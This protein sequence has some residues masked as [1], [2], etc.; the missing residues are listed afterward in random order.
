MKDILRVAAVPSV[1]GA[2][3]VLGAVVVL[4]LAA[5]LEEHVWPP[6]RDW[7]VTE[8]YVDGR[9]VVLVGL[10]VKPRDCTYVPPPRARDETG[11]NYLVSST[12]PTR[13]TSW[14]T[15]ERPQRF[16][17]WRVAGGA[18]KQLTFY[19]EFRCHPAWNIVIEHG[20]L[21]TRTKE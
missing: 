8:W 11:Q 15:S 2:A 10:V 9:D 16:G 1:A 21:D 12:S 6:M 18:G 20:T 17:P 5:K 19:Q 4:P 7:R 13:V 3:V 14:G